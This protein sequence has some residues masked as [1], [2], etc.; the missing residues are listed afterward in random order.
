MFRMRRTVRSVS[1]MLR[2]HILMQLAS[3]TDLYGYVNS[4]CSVRTRMFLDDLPLDM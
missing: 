4:G 2:N 3:F 1:T